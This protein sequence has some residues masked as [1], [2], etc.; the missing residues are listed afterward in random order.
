MSDQNLADMMSTISSGSDLLERDAQGDLLPPWL[1][2]PAIPFGSIGWRMG[3]GE[4]YWDDFR[5]WYSHLDGPRRRALQ[6]RY[7]AT[8][9]WRD[10]Y[11]H[12]NTCSLRDV[13]RA[14]VIGALVGDALGVPF[15]FMKP[16][17]LPPTE[18]IRMVMPADF[19]KTH[20]HIPYGTWSDDGSQLLCLL[21]ALTAG[22][23]WTFDAGRFGE[24]LLRWMK[25]AH[26][27][28]GGV[29][30]D[31]GGQT[32][33]AL[34]LIGQGIPAAKTGG[35]DERSNGNGSLMR[36]LPVAL[37]A[38]LRGWSQGEVID[39]AQAQSCVTH[40]HPL[41]QVCCA[42][43][44][45][46]ARTLIREPSLT[47]H[48]CYA[49]ASA[50]LR[51]LYGSRKQTHHLSALARVDD[52]P[53][54]SFRRGSG[55]VVDSLWTAIDCLDSSSCY[56]DVVRAAIGYGNDTDTTACIA[57]GLAGIRYGIDHQP[58]AGEALGIPSDWVDALAVPHASVSLLEGVFGEAFGKMEG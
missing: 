3:G 55:F 10:F 46:M 44:S 38:S 21:E 47:A 33:R 12:L 19:P 11:F 56:V 31:C 58:L 35:E 25:S 32:T 6:A 18:D 15:E 51:S 14:A 17:Q 50:E 43:Y 37:V 41:A 39:V 48:A 24:L 22:E 53:A 36:C 42:A 26:H 13:C 52:F 16:E 30:F 23:N 20:G 2:Y 54:S 57:G 49:L 9:A 27:Q 28:A 7:P 1:R 4:A 8:G 29:V 45:L 5:L 40:A 34:T